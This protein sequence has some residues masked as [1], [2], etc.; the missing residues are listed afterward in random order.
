MIPAA[1][2]SALSAMLSCKFIVSCEDFLRIPAQV[3]H[4]Q[5]YRLWEFDQLRPVAVVVS[6]PHPRY[7]RHSRSKTSVAAQPRWV[8]RG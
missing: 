2:L 8:I 4:G 1:I 6:G 5:D 3:I 7:Q